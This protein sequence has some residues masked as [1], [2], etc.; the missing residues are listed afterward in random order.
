MTNQAAP[1]GTRQPVTPTVTVV[2]AEDLAREL[3]AHNSPEAKAQRLVA[4]KK[5][6]R[7]GLRVQVENGLHEILVPA[8][9]CEV[10]ADGFKL[11]HKGRK[12]LSRWENASFVSEGHKV[13]VLF[14]S[15]H[16]Y[17]HVV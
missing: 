7:V 4:I 10:N 12:T 3:K 14:D 5:L 2:T 1:R 8:K 11:E 17:T 13:P 15:D 6:I 9:V 16:G